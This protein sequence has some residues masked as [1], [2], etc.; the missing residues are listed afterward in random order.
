[1]APA[2]NL[3]KRVKGTQVTRPFIVGTT[4]RPFNPE[5]NPKPGNVPEDHT[6]SWQVF[7]KGVDDVDVTHWLRRIQFKLHESIPNPLRSTLIS[8]HDPFPAADI[9]A[10]EAKEK[11]E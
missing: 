6:H 2:N 11:T 1:M 10:F 3:G 8:L 9:L 5:T 7:V 4:A